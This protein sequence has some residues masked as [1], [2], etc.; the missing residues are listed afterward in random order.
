MKN[1][2]KTL[3]RAFCI[4]LITVLL[5]VMASCAIRK[6]RLPQYLPCPA[7]RPR[8]HWFLG[9]GAAK[10]SPYRSAQNIRESQNSLSYDY[11]NQ[12]RQFRGKF[13]AYGYNAFQLQAMALAIEKGEI[14]DL[15]IPDN[16]FIQGLKLAEYVNKTL[17]NTLWK[18]EHSFLCGGNGYPKRRGNGFWQREQRLG[19]KGKLFRAWSVSAGSYR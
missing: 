9:A 15:I 19:G 12:R 18:I 17:K 8:L 2:E 11:R 6:F 1:H 10:V 3:P 14:I 5:F 7:N 16:G 4:L 13:Y